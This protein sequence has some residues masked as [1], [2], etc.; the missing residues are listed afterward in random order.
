MIT[1]PKPPPP[2]PPLADGHRK[3]A[4][5]PRSAHG[6]RTASVSN[7]SNNAHLI[8]SGSN[9]WNDAP[10]SIQTNPLRSS[11]GHLRR[12][13]WN[14]VNGTRSV[15]TPERLTSTLYEVDE[16]DE[17]KS[18]D[19][20]QSSFR[21]EKANPAS[22][23]TARTPT[24]VHTRQHSRIHERNLSAFFPRPGQTGEGYGDAF[25]DPHR[26]QIV[27]AMEQVI[28]SADK[29][30]NSTR[31]SLGRRGHHHKH[32]VSHNF[33][34]F[35]Q[36]DGSTTPSLDRSSL[37]SVHRDQAQ[38]LSSLSPS[39]PDKRRSASILPISKLSSRGKIALIVATCQ[40]AIG[41]S[42]WLS[43]QSRE[44]LATTGLGYLVV[45]DGMGTLSGVLIGELGLESGD[46]D[47]LAKP[48]PDAV[49]MPFG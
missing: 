3:Q 18:E 30:N 41:A 49:K 10:E 6:R 26:A 40:V 45:F 37:F 17:G 1:T 35:T 33:F 28:R 7:V 32:S 36:L 29:P 5:L 4:A 9:G 24:H 11:N 48:V 23:S 2:P 22:D 8:A 19:A 39:T 46:P 31:T 42:L 25:T 14:Q 21:P 15:S 12:P 16:E 47:R 43:G 20:D 13:S 34:S 44:S 27:S 38:S